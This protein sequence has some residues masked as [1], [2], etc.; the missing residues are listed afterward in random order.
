MRNDPTIVALATKYGV[1]SAQIILAW[2]LARGVIAVPKS[3]N[4]AHQKENINLPTLSPEDFQQVAA[5]DRG[6]RICNKANDRGIVWGW[7]YEQLGW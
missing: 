1:T 6:Q 2:H 5:L 7:T 4:P 3:A